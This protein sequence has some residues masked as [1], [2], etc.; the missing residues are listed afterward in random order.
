VQLPVK[1]SRRENSARP[2]HDWPVQACVDL[3]RQTSSK[4][5]DAT[6]HNSQ[7]LGLLLGHAHARLRQSFGRGP[8]NVP[9]ACNYGTNYL[10][11]KLP[12]LSR[13]SRPKADAAI[14]GH[15]A[16]RRPCA[17]QALFTLCFHHSTAPHNLAGASPFAQ[18]FH[19][20][21]MILTTQ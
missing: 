20:A 7:K 2:Y 10:S 1:G 9:D 18:A 11:H 6:P 4:Q 17:A 19:I 15:P 3:Y 21:L 8:A 14:P 16:R 12:C 13:N 5:S